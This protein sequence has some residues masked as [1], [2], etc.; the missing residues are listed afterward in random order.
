[1]FNL[2]LDLVARAYR[3]FYHKVCQLPEPFTRVFCRMEQFEPVLFWGL[4]LFFI[5]KADIGHWYWTVPVNLFFLWF[6][7]HIVR[8]RVCHPE[9]LPYL[10]K[11]AE[12][13]LDEHGD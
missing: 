9:N 2:L 4:C 8:Y 1:L 5:W 7:P 12:R 11:W 13:R 3:F 10:L 6:I